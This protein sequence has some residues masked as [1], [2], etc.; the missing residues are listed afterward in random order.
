MF[1]LLFRCNAAKGAI[2]RLSLGG[3]TKVK[4]LKSI[5]F[6]EGSLKVENNKK[7]WNSD[8]VSPFW[9]NS[10]PIKNLIAMAWVW[11]YV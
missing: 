8:N 5:L 11:Q 6:T 9:R 2:S 4:A 10:D 7:M 3:P 1:S